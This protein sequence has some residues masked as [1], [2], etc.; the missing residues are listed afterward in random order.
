M[1]DRTNLSAFRTITGSPVDSSSF[2][3]IRTLGLSLG[4][5][6]D[7]VVEALRYKPESRGIDFRW[8]NW[9]FSLT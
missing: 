6:G 3:F 9:N 5:R 4:I 2:H 8:C 1:M 7:T